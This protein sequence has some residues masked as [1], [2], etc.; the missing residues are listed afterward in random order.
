VSTLAGSGGAGFADGQGTA[1][2]FNRPT[3]IAVDNEGNII[4]ADYDNHRIRKI[5]PGGAVST[6]AGS[7][8]AGFADGQ[9]T[10]AHFHFP[11]D[12]AVDNEGNII[13]ADMNNHRIRKIT[14]GGAV[15]TLAG[16]GGGGGGFGGGGFGGGGFGGG[17]G[18]AFADGQGTAARFHSPTGV[19]V[20]EEG[21]VI[22]TDRD[23]SCIRT[24]DADLTP[25]IAAGRRLPSGYAAEML[26][27]FN[28]PTFADITLVVGET[29]IPAHRAI[30]A[31]R[32]EYFKTMLTGNFQEGAAAA[33]VGANTRRLRVEISDT[34]PAT[35]RALL[36]YLYTD[37]LLFEDADLVDVMRKAQEIQLHR[38]FNFVVHSAYRQVTDTN[39]VPWFI[40]AD[41]LGLAALRA[42]ALRFLVRR[43]RGERAERAE[44]FNQSL[45]MLEEHPRLMM[46]LLHA[47]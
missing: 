8:G 2:H 10:A 28:D 20:D 30:L 15:S 25:A 1:A 13:V 27:M 24:I 35:L 16:S 39:A 7:G 40:Q 44:Q 43:Y 19:A 6:L 26:T 36:R 23:N 9:G 33:G 38:V 12:V 34:K 46:E 14:P 22:V 47:I 32:S 3:G 17:G 18:G 45:K 29:E 37:E 11:F 4:V 5:T 31:A 21:N 42:T 41:Q